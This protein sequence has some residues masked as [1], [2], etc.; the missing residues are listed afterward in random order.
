MAERITGVNWQRI[1]WCCADRRMSS[2]ALA[3]AT[4]ISET[5][6][7]L[8]QKG[9]D[10]LT[11][12]QLQKVANYFGRGVLFFLEPGPASADAVFSTGFRTLANQKYEMEGAVRKIIE[13]AEWQREAY[14]ELRAEAGDEAIAAFSPP[15]FS[16]LSIAEAASAARIWL[17]T[18]RANSFEAYR[19]SVEQKGILVFRTNGYNGKWQ[20][21]KASSILGFSIYHKDLPLIV[22]RKTAFESRQTFTLFHELAHILL[23]KESVIDDE[24]DFESHTKKEKEAN[25]FA[26]LILVPEGRLN[27]VDARQLPPHPWQL[28]EY[29]SAYRRRWGVSTE[30]LLLR[31]LDSERIGRDVYD[32]YRAW[33]STQPADESPAA[34]RMYRYR[35]PKNILGDGYVRTVLS[36]LEDRRITLTRASKFLDGLKVNDLHKLGE[37]YASH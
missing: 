11:F 28:D 2:E 26:S 15:D 4:S 10:A 35:E 16:D 33:R 27:L 14:I 8:L 12:P 20:I 22:V 24:S 1:A 29:L 37:H 13:R 9:H 34:P 3:L 17:G 31:L 25:A 32:G 23:H 7:D 18:D 21:P 36:A 6:F 5:T 19:Q 30:V